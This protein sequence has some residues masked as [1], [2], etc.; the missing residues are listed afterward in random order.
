MYQTQIQ[1]THSGSHFGGISLSGDRRGS[2]NY[3]GAVSASPDN[4]AGSGGGRQARISLPSGGGAIRS[5]GEKFEANPATGTASFT[6]P[7]T[8]SEGRDGFTPQLALSYDSGGGN[9]AFGLG[10]NVG[11]PGITRKTDKGIPRYGD[12]P[13][14]ETDTFI[15]AGAEDLAPVM[16]GATRMQRSEG[17]CDVYI[18]QPRTEGLFAMIERWTNRNTRISHWRS[19]SRD[20]NTCIYGLSDSARIADPD[21]PHRIFSWLIEESWDAKG[22]LIRFSY[23]KED[24]AGVENSS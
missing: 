9:S 17:D 11:L 5:I 24:G 22:N 21:N 20:N 14:R 3:R 10:W 15:L 1:N 16:N 12:H 23:K 2:M 6:V 8:I 4:T 18:Y 7:L 19:I 13:E